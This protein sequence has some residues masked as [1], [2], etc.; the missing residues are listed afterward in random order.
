MIPGNL[1]P[2]ARISALA[3][4]SPSR[5][6]ALEE[7]ALREAWSANG[8]DALLP[9]HPSARLGTAIHGI[10]ESA[11]KGDLGF[12]DQEAV[13]RAWNESVIAL[14]E[15]MR[16]SWLERSLLPL[17]KTINQFEVQRLRTVRKA[18]E[19]SSSLKG[20]SK[21]PQPGRAGL[22]FEL[23]VSTPKGEIGGF[24]D[25]AY[26]IDGRVVLEDY[27]TGL[28]LEQNSDGED[29]LKTDY[30]TQLHI[31]AALYFFTFGKWPRQ[32]QV[33]TTQGPPVTVSVDKERSLELALAAKSKLSAINETILRPGT[34]DKDIR[35][36]LAAPSASACK[37]CLFRPNCDPYAEARAKN[38]GS[39]PNDI[40]GPLKDRRTF[41]NG[42]TSLTIE[43]DGSLC[44]VRSVSPGVR[45]PGLETAKPGDTIGCFNLRKGTGE[46]Q[47]QETPYTTIYHL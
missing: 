44:A 27:K 5:Y 46:S 35:R 36:D 2:I 43:H 16:Q 26:E 34:G 23:W 25:H 9:L 14:E 6:L 37:R 1:S 40:R 21:P 19:I 10:L 13:E 3:R 42:Y 7:G 8:A 39:W 47:Y 28:V 45:H 4:I 11:G 31:Y 38:Q 15:E 29:T 24:I 32:L 33:V 12:G 41:A 22:G 30:L 17:S 18:C 20:P